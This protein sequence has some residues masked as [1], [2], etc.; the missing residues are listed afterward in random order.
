VCN[1]QIATGV[2]LLLQ[3]QE[4]L[5]QLLNSYPGEVYRTPAK[6]QRVFHSVKIPTLRKRKTNIVY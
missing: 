6:L 2:F 3:I 5:V 1:C 4:I